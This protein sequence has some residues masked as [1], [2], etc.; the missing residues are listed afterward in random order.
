MQSS[1]EFLVTSTFTP[2]PAP[3]LQPMEPPAC[4]ERS[5]DAE[6]RSLA[7]ENKNTEALKMYSREI[8]RIKDKIKKGD[9][10]PPVKNASAYII[11]G[12]EV[13][14]ELSQKNPNMK[15]VDTVRQ[16]AQQWK[17]LSAKRRQHYAKEAK[18]GKQKLL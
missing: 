8:S 12:R 6:Q 11:F 15:V 2:T 13:R 7:D 10:K 16:I 3:Q 18:K 5:P 9:I 14:S 1:F 4:A 17:L